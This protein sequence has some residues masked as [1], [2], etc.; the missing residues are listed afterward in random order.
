MICRQNAPN[1]IKYEML[2]I[3]A[4]HRSTE[5]RCMKQDLQT[6]VMIYPLFLRRILAQVDSEI[7]LD[8]YILIHVGSLWNEQIVVT[9]L[10]ICYKI[11]L[12]DMFKY[13][14]ILI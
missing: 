6:H 13:V 7:G 4:M 1:S 14:K 10:N 2:I 12:L 11:Q 9:P 3:N 5:C 8:E